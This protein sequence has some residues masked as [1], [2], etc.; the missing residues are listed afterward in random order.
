MDND[1]INYIHNEECSICLENILL[2]N[3]FI[4]ICEH[5]FHNMRTYFS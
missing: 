1:N 5:I 2:E 3:K 4:T